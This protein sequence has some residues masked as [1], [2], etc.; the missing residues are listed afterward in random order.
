MIVS[1]SRNVLRSPQLMSRTMP[2]STKNHHFTLLGLWKKSYSSCSRRK[3]ACLSEFEKWLAENPLPTIALKN[4]EEDEFH[5]SEIMENRLGTVDSSS[6]D[7]SCDENWIFRGNDEASGKMNFSWKQSFE[8]ISTAL[9]SESYRWSK[10]KKCFF[11]VQFLELC[12]FSQVTP[13]HFRNN[14]R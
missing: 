4:T 10:E 3:S 1:Y 14:F 8:I 11:P 13:F 6:N 5:T 9:H 2:F 7:D 12:N